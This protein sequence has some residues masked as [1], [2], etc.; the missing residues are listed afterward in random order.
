MENY[1]ITY[2]LSTYS[3]TISANICLSAY[4]LFLKHLN[5]YRKVDLSHLQCGILVFFTFNI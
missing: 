3:D 2:N 1:E 5:I 4:Y